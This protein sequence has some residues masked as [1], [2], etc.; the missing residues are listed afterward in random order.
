[1]LVMDNI[2]S[3]V[4]NFHGL[5]DDAID[6]TDTA[7]GILSSLITAASN[8]W[9]AQTKADSDQQI[10]EQQKLAAAQAAQLKAAQAAQLKASEPFLTKYMPY[11]S[12]AGVIATGAYI[13]FKYVKE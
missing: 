5:G 8:I 10:M 6:T 13:Y 3:K 12:I 11:I 4:S 1:M 9:T 2:K 7:S